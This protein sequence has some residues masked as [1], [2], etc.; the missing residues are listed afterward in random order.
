MKRFYEV[1]IT[2][3]NVIEVDEDEVREKCEIPDDEEIPEEVFEGWV[4]D[5]IAEYIEANDMRH[6]VN[7]VEFDRYIP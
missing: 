7:D 3:L 4:Q 1:S 5:S 2:V 6:D